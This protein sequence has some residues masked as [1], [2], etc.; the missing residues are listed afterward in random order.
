MQE[1]EIPFVNYQNSFI[2]ILC[3][4]DTKMINRSYADVIA[5]RLF[6]YIF[7]SLINIPRRPLHMPQLEG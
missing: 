5:V 3:Q 2:I 1:I 4:L 6:Y 7:V